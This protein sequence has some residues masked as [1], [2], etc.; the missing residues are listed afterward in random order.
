MVPMYRQLIT[1]TDPVYYRKQS[2]S[3]SSQFEACL[4]RW[5]KG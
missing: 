3:K 4:E 2:A 1:K 5:M